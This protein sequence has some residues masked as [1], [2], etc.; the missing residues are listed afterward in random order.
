MSIEKFS[1]NARGWYIAYVDTDALTLTIHSDW[2]VWGHR[3]PAS[4]QPE[5]TA[6]LDF[7]F[8]DR[9][10][11]FAIYPFDYVTR[12]LFGGDATTQV[13][14]RK[15]RTALRRA[16]K[17]RAQELWKVCGRGSPALAADI[18]EAEELITQW[19][20]GDDARLDDLTGQ[21]F[22]DDAYLH[23][24]TEPSDAFRV[25]CDG[26]LPAIA[27]QYKRQREVAAE[28]EAFYVKY[29]EHKKFKAI[30]SEARVVSEF[31]DHEGLDQ[32]AKRVADFFEINENAFYR[33]Q[34]L[35]LAEL[36]RKEP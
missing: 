16:L 6:F 35:M 19:T 15:T 13:H 28:R 33:E 2:G 31:I 25:V 11:V 24:H 5:G 26:I 29:P 14:E 34:T 8:H 12:K 27:T 3:W 1:G 23:V 9:G 36:S 20:D 10:G 30:E 22:P 32:G 17:L 7:L 18:C 21:F 4:G